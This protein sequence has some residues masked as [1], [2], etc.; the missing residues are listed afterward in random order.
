VT[1]RDLVMAHYHPVSPLRTRT[2]DCS[3]VAIIS[4]RN[5]AMGRWLRWC[6]KHVVSHYSRGLVT[7]TDHHLLI[8]D[9]ILAGTESRH[10]LLRRG[11][12]VLHSSTMHSTVPWIWHQPVCFAVTLRERGNKLIGSISIYLDRS[13]LPFHL[14]FWF[15]H[16]AQCCPN[17]SIDGIM[18]G[19]PCYFQLVPKVSKDSGQ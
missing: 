17:R 5:W 18:A 2:C 11:T 3:R 9:A 6:Y 15:K 13:H 14:K 1:I 16:G 19:L 10:E 8:S 7:T 4:F 12:I